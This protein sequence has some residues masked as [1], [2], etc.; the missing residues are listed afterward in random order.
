M[1]QPYYNLVTTW[2]KVR[3]YIK[4][5]YKLTYSDS[6]GV[7]FWVYLLRTFDTSQVLSLIQ[8]QGLLLTKIYLHDIYEHPGQ[9]IVD[10]ISY[11]P[12]GRPVYHLPAGAATSYIRKFQALKRSNSRYSLS[13]CRHRRRRRATQM[14][15]IDYHSYHLQPM[16]Y[17]LIWVPS[18][19]V[20]E[21]LTFFD[22]LFQHD[23][24]LVRQQVLYYLYRYYTNHWEDRF[25]NNHPLRI[26]RQLI[27]RGVAPRCLD[28]M[29]TVRSRQTRQSIAEH[30]FS[31]FIELTIFRL[32]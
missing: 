18:E 28:I 1:P 25:W 10:Q 6:R 16:V 24:P 5:G 9:S 22:Y 19:Q 29:A 7:P 17:R 20:A 4:A 3:R 31:Y 21:L 12:I 27:E 13:Y 8:S 23:V 11:R 2:T 30:L 15:F 26:V 14:L 32:Q